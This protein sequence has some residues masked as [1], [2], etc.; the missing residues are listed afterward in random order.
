MKNIL[1][2]TGGGLSPALNPAIYGVAKSAQKHGIKLWGGLYGWRCLLPEGKIK[3]L[4]KLDL[5]P[6][7]ERGGTFLRSSRTNPLSDPNNLELIKQKLK[8]LKIDGVVAIGGDD[9][10]GAAAK[11]AEFGL[12]IVGIPKTI[13]N[14]LSGTHFTLG[15]PSAAHYLADFTKQIKEDAAYA[16]SRIFVIEALGMKAGWL[17]AAAIYGKADII[18]PPEWPVDLDHTLQIIKER[19][20]QNGN[21]AVVVVAQE[22]NFQGKLTTETDQQP[23]EQYGHK[24]NHYICLALR[25][26]IKTELKIDTKALYPG[27]YLESDKPIL[28][29]QKFAIEAGKKAVELILKKNFGMAPIIKNKNGKLKTEIISLKKMVG[30]EKYNRLPEEYFD[31]NKMLPT[32][33]FEKYLQTILGKIPRDTSYEKLIKKINS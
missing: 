20:K 22:A 5:S 30:G 27:N 1:V 11:L 6:L 3:D 24:R 29:D 2:F 33:Q 13:D 9:T 32:K 31:R 4:S 21:Y 8:N 12:P 15:F 17:A 10:L 7:K 28:L 14:D 23:G 25:D 26:K 16:L 18:I 19:Y